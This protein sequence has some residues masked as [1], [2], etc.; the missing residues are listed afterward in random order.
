MQQPGKF[1]HQ[2]YLNYFQLAYTPF[3]VAPDNSDFFISDHSD[4][5]ISNLTRAIFSRKGFMLLTGDIGLGK[6]TLSRRII[7]ILDDNNVETSLIF[8]SFFQEENLL[9]EIIRDFGIQVD[10][11]DDNISKLMAKLIPF[12]LAKNKKGINCAIIIDDAQNLSKESLELVRMISNLESDKEKLVQILLVGQPELM[13]TL[14]DHKLRQLKSR[15]TLIETCIPLTRDQVGQYVQFKLTM[16]G[17]TGRIQLTSKAAKKLFDLTGGNLRR[18]NIL[19]DHSLELAFLANTAT[20]KPDFFDTAAK[21]LFLKQQSAPK[22][23]RLSASLV[24]ILILFMAVGIGIGTGIFYLNY[25]RMKSADPSREAV[26]T[27]PVPKPALKTKV[28]AGPRLVP[29]APIAVPDTPKQKISESVASFM[30]AYDLD[31]Y[32]LEFQQALDQSAFKKTAQTIFDQTGRQLIILDKIPELI[33]GKYHVLSGMDKATDQKQYYL[34]WRPPYQISH[35]YHRYS[36]PEIIKL[37]EMLHE[38]KLYRY[39]IDGIVGHRVLK[40]VKDFQ[41]TRELSET[42][43]PDQETV[44]LLANTVAKN[45]SVNQTKDT[46]D[47]ATPTQKK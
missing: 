35:F 14:N 42:G 28:I 11:G 31:N 18:I 26:V 7:Q 45:R 8:Q 41:R 30:A 1:N 43:F 29:S 33:E 3:P 47:G 37:Q 25:K 46:E 19:M 13:D 4:A 36:G 40:S 20:I 10:A 6:T 2:N 17:D 39:E 9:T 44:F 38:L 22:D 12:L 23:I 27:L 24:L 16:A 15:I 5:V 21:A 34:F 32:A